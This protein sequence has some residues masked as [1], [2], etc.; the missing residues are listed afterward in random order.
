MELTVKELA[1]RLGAE[2]IGNG[3]GVVRSVGPVG[4]ADQTTL[5]FLTDNKHLS[6]LKKS[7]CG[8]VIINKAIDEFSQPQLIVKDVST[9]LIEAL[10][11]FGQTGAGCA[12][13][14]L[15]RQSSCRR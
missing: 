7:R 10:K 2:L 11:I 13:R 3:A 9:A 4:L 8:A 12:G 14:G 6:E 5:T 1:N 15:D